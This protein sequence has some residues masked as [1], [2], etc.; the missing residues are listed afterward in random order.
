LLRR[1]PSK[2][3]FRGAESLAESR[4]FKRPES[5]FGHLEKRPKTTI[6][7]TAC[8]SRLCARRNASFMAQIDQSAPEI[9]PLIRDILEGLT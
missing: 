5:A 7:S 3:R 8:G 9:A 2:K 6:Y 1:R 4:F